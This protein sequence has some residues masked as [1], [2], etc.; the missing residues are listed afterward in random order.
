M[1]RAVAAALPPLLVLAADGDPSVRRSMVW[2][3]A[4]CEEASLPLMPL[5]RARLA[6]EGD[7]EVRA[8]LVTALGL[9]DASPE[10]RDAHNRALLAGAEPVVRGAA[11]TDLLRTAALPLPAAWADAALDVRGAARVLDGDHPWPSRY[12]PLGERLLDDPEAALRAVRRGLSLAW[13]LTERWRD[14]EGDVLPWLAEAATDVEGLCRVARAGSALEGGAPAPWLESALRSEDPAVRV[15]A[16]QAAVRLRVPGALGLVLRLMDELPQEAATL[17]LT[18]S[19][20]PGAVVRAAVEVFGAAARPVALRV[21]DR[22]CAGW[23]EALLPFPELAAG[24]AAACGPAPGPVTWRRRRRWPT[25]RG[26]RGPRWPWCGRCRIPRSG[27]GRP[28][29]WPPNSGR[30][31]GPCCRWWRSGCWLLPGRAGLT[32]PRRSGASPAGRTTPR[33]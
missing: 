1:R 15:V 14:R 21:A 4:A 12:R 30:A 5:L 27:A 29:R 17:A 10:V 28:C 23:V 24:C 19:S 3:I 20:A 8:D 18:P 11:L 31:P 9:L 26:M 2:I 7:A 22:P 16:V 13:E 33:P 32:R 25:S 6:E